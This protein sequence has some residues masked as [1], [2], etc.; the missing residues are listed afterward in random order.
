MPEQGANIMNQAVRELGYKLGLSVVSTG[1]ALPHVVENY[2]YWSALRILLT[3]LRINCVFDVGANQGQFASRLRQSGYQGHILSFE[4]NPETF[5]L[6]EQ[7]SAGDTR[8]QPFNFALGAAEAMLPFNIT[9]SDT[10]SSFLD[11][12]E[13]ADSPAP[14]LGTAVMR[15]EMVQVGRLDAMLDGLVAG[16]P[17][18]R[19]FLKCDTQGF[20]LEVVRGAEGCMDRILGLQSEISVNPLYRGG[21]HYLD[22]L[23][24]YESLGLSLMDLFVV[25][26]TRHRA[27][28]EYDCLM[29]RTAA[30]ET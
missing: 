15:T 30:L 16:I 29:A 13:K 27:V 18:P 1:F 20:D 25:N 3:R 8:W 6:L 19:I 12:L 21:P 5:R 10:L 11:P 14:E 7:A 2:S 9:R 4:P 28:L 24:T 22:A 17:A 23:R 26:R